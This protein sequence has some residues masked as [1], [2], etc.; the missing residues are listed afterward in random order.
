MFPDVAGVG[1]VEIPGFLGGLPTAC[2][3]EKRDG[4]HYGAVD[5]LAG[6]PR[7]PPDAAL[8]P[9]TRWHELVGCGSGIPSP[10]L[11]D[12]V[13]ELL[14]LRGWFDWKADPGG[15]QGIERLAH[16]DRGSALL[17][18]PAKREGGGLPAAPARRFRGGG[19]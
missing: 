16:A 5:F 13:A 19:R 8:Y 14:G 11:A 4:G 1:A 12:S 15:F 3:L 17:A 6:S 2:A 10:H 7:C 9:S 18:M